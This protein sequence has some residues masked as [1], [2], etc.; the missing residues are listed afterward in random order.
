VDDGDEQY[1]TS[2]SIVCAAWDAW[3]DAQSGIA[4]YQMAVGTTTTQANILAWTTVPLDT[5]ACVNAS[6]P[7]GGPYYSGACVSTVVNES[8]YTQEEH[9]RA[10]ETLPLIRNN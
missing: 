3:E 5:T 7:E 9:T 6:L 4:M 1:I 8:L 10:I 2:Q